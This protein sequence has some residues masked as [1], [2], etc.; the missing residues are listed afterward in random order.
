MN[1][2]EIWLERSLYALFREAK[3]VQDVW[4]Q[5]SQRRRAAYALELKSLRAELD[6]L[7][8]E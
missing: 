2:V 7:L 6:K 1:D 8:D 3:D 4:G 5:V